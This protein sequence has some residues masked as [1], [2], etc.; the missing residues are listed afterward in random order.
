MKCSFLALLVSVSA[1]SQ[2]T[3]QIP[4]SKEFTTYLKDRQ[5]KL[6]MKIYKLASEGK[7]KAFCSDSLNTIYSSKKIMEQYKAC[8]KYENEEPIDYL[9]FDEE[10]AFDVQKAERVS[11][12]RSVILFN[13]RFCERLSWV[14]P[15]F[16]ADFRELQSLLAKEELEFIVNVF[17]H[18]EYYNTLGDY[19]RDNEPGLVDLYKNV[20]YQHADTNLTRRMADILS[21]RSF[22]IKMELH[23][24]HRIHPM[25]FLYSESSKATIGLDS[26]LHFYS[27]DSVFSISCPDIGDCYDSVVAFEYFVNSIIY[28][29]ATGQLLKYRF[30]TRDADKT[31]NTIFQV[32]IHRDFYPSRSKLWF[33][34]D[35]LKWKKK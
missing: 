11:K 19:T 5:E 9:G 31:K 20:I 12:L 21:S 32:D 26:F 33:Y 17:Y 18:S 15:F 4:S 3:L 25:L 1:Y 22:N 16:F 8:H 34:H 23:Q 35:Y 14:E 29:K 2:D 27:N 10:V 7:V 13:H 30:V 24:M 6:W 28:N